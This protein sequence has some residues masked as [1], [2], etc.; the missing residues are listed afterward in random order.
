MNLQKIIIFTMVMAIA[1]YASA[2]F[3]IEKIED[4]R[5]Y[6]IKENEVLPANELH[7]AKI[8]EVSRT[9][10]RFDTLKSEKR[11]QEWS[12][13]GNFHLQSK[14]GREML[15][16]NLEAYWNASKKEIVVFEN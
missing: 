7:R 11:A 8:L 15:R 13:I 14:E 16:H 1:G 10:K 2:E 9:D 6:A 12:K 5:S 3:R 4:I